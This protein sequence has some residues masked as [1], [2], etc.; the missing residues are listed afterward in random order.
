MIDRDPDTYLGSLYGAL[1]RRCAADPHLQPASLVF[2]LAKSAVST[3][4]KAVDEYAKKLEPLVNDP[5]RLSGFVKFLPIENQL[6]FDFFANGLAALESFC[7]ASYYVGALIDSTQFNGN[8]NPRGIDPKRAFDCF[9][10]I[11]PT[12]GFTL[13]LCACLN[14]SEFRLLAE[15]KNMLLHTPAPGRAV[16][17]LKP[18]AAP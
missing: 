7:F 11:N 8:K 3:R 6:L 17:V 9:Y 12:D 18:N 10:S 5:N 2:H 14:S 13:G 15:M 16:R 4:M 1:D